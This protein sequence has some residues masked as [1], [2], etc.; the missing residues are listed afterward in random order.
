MKEQANKLKGL[1][2]E[3]FKAEG[4]PERSCQVYTPSMVDYNKAMELYS[5]ALGIYP[6]G[7][8]EQEVAICLANRA[9]CHMKLVCIVTLIHKLLF[10][11]RG[12]TKLS[13]KI[14]QKVCYLFIV[15][16]Y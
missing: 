3:A 7:H 1:G 16:S 10:V 14:A 4:E 8:C 15:F 2:N 13:L 6:P 12:N 5:E 9:A 11:I